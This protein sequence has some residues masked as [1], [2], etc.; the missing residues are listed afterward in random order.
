MVKVIISDVKRD[1]LEASLVKED[2]KYIVLYPTTVKDAKRKDTDAIPGTIILDKNVNEED[3]KCINLHMVVSNVLND[4]NVNYA[5]FRA[6]LA[7]VSSFAQS[8]GIDIIILSGALMTVLAPINE[9][10]IAAIIKEMMIS[11]ESKVIVCTKMVDE[12][13]DVYDVVRSECKKELPLAEY[14]NKKKDKKGKK[15]KKKHKK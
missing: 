7:A 9:Y 3:G 8:E 11:T 2:S 10:E 13:Y 12:D 1:E 14:G 15:N 4:C 6:A 5:A